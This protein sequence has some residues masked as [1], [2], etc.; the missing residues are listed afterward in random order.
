MQSEKLVQEICRLMSSDVLCILIYN[1]CTPCLAVIHMTEVGPV[2]AFCS[3]KPTSPTGS[4][5]PLLRIF[6]CTFYNEAGLLL[7]KKWSGIFII[8]CCD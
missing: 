5:C 7:A 1:T 6:I 2:R 4:C 3:Q 8:R